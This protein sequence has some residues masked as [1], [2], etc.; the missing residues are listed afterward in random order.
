MWSTILCQQRHIRGGAGAV[1]IARG[2]RASET[3]T[4]RLCFPRTKAFE[5]S[6]NLHLLLLDIA[7]SAF[8]YL[9]NKI[10]DESQAVATD[11][12]IL[13]VAEALHSY[14]RPVPP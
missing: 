5:P 6:V 12:H 11:R 13:G 4:H 14:E 8:P 10:A 2:S 1:T 9:G 3:P 7:S